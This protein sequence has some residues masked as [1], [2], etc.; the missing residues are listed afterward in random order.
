MKKYALFAGSKYY[1]SGGWLDFQGS[2]DSVDEAQGSIRLY[3][4]WWQIVD[5]ET[6]TVVHEF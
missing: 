3:H 2:F 4:E 5:L 1:P 6:G